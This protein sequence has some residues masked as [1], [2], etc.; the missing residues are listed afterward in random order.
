MNK[1]QCFG[2]DLKVNWATSGANAPKMDTSKHY[3]IF[4]GD[5][6][7]DLETPQL[8]DAFIPFGEISDCRVVRDP[9]TFKSKNYGFVSFVKKTDAENAIQTMNGQWLGSRA[10]RTNWATRKPPTSRS[11]TLDISTSSS[12]PIS[13][14]PKQLSFEEVYNQSS[15]T[16]CTVYCGGL[17]QGLTDELIQKTFYPFG[18]IQEIRVFKDKG[19]CGLLVCLFYLTPFYGFILIFCFV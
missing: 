17:M 7:A 16:N 15:P 19:K 9:Q 6:S 14:S 2:R 13:S 5:L 8:K 18:P 10:I 1:R 11:N 4:V 12:Q 3:H